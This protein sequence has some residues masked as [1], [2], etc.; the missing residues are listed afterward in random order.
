MCGIIGYTGTQD[1][2][3]VVLAGLKN[4]EY[5]GYDS[6]G[7]ATHPAI[8]ITKRVG[9][10]GEVASAELGRSCCAVGHT[11][12]ATH[13]GVTQANA[14]PHTDRSGSIVVVHNGIIENHERIREQL[15]HH[16]FASDTDTETIPHLIEHHMESGLGFE[17][18]V[19]RTVREL[20]GSFAIVA[21]HKDSPN[22]VCARQGSPLV[23]GI[24]DGEHFVAS[25]VTAFIEHT[26]RVVFLEDGELAVING[27]LEIEDFATGERKGVKEQTI[28]W[29]VEQAM[30]GN[31][32]H[33]MLKEIFEQPETVAATLRGRI[34]GNALPEIDQAL[35]AGAERIVIVAC[36]TSWH[37][38]LVGKSM[39]ED[40][41]RV[42]VDVEYASEFRYRDPLI[43]DDTIIVP[44][45]QSGETADTLA[46]LRLGKERGAKTISVCNVIGSTIARESDAVVYTRAGPEIGVASTKAFTSQLA[47]LAAL[48]LALGRAK[49]TLH[50]ARYR[51]LTKALKA[52]PALITTIL[53][54]AG[55]AKRLAQ[56]YADRKN[57]LYLGRGPNFPIALEGALKLKEVSYIHAEGYPAAEMKHG[58]IAL[59]DKEMPTVFIAPKD[60]TYAKVLGNIEEVKARGGKVVA[61]ATEGDTQVAAKADD[62]LFIPETDHLLVPFLAVV[63]LQLLAYHIAVLRHCDVDKPRNLAKSVTVE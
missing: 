58:P 49:G 62:I 42:P 14:H 37:A 43:Q 52:I 54:N 9:K 46:A 17:D 1:A 55:E 25:D 50:D 56:R 33:F 19:R 6:W 61:V 18:A 22:M 45:S 13:G 21:L 28:D 27:T 41:A 51:Q 10:V 38:G 48:A 4:L 57:A 47:V 23:I 32:D 39:I 2:T 3:Q 5:R 15:S 53:A 44:I 31:Y 20:E 26:N 30:K 11:R 34:N 59:I 29:S 24:G 7:I 16:A 35:L 8:A 40:L 12:W 63:P 36:G 60:A